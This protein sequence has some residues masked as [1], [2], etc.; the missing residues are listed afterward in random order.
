MGKIKKHF[1]VE[2]EKKKKR[3]GVSLFSNL[4]RVAC[5]L[6]FELV[7]PFYKTNTPPHTYTHIVS[8]SQ[9]LFRADDHK[10]L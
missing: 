2:G 8:V 9:H 7:Q 5:M 4:L 3:K 10:S 1:I 6:D